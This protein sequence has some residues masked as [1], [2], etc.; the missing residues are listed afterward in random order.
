MNLKKIPRNRNHNW[1]YNLISINSI[2]WKPKS[3]FYIF[4]YSNRNRNWNFVTLVILIEIDM[5]IRFAW[6]TCLIPEKLFFS[7]MTKEF[8][9]TPSCLLSAEASLGFIWFRVCCRRF[10]PTLTH[11][12]SCWGSEEEP[13][14]WALHLESSSS[15]S[16]PG[17]LHKAKVRFG[18]FK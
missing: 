9:Y 16:V 2:Q 12:G 10:D 11:D 8:Y 18:I 1:N 7:V 5:E 3:K 4:E 15:F 6:R 17:D 13:W 14:V